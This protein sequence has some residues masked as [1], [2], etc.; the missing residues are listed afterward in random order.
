M[1]S[2]EPLPD[3][4]RKA[5]LRDQLCGSADRSSLAAAPPHLLVCV[6]GR[7]GGSSKHCHLHIAALEDEVSPP[8]KKHKQSI[9]CTNVLVC[10]S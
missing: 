6:C 7:R 1:H 2:D 8:R 10:G 4:L 9:S 3:D 5:N